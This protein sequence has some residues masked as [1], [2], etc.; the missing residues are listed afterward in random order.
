MD[1]LK[2]TEK[3]PTEA[4]CYAK[5]ERVRWGNRPVCPKCGCTRITKRTARKNYYHCNACNRDFTA[6]YGT[7]F[8]GSKMP[9]RKWFLLI[10][11][12]LNSKKGV[13]AMNLSR[14]VGVTYKTA[15]YSAM[16]VRCA[17]LDWGEE[18]EGI[19]E[20]DETY[21]GGKPRKR[22]RPL[23]SSDNTAD[24]SKIY[25]R[26]DVSV[27]RGRGTKKVPVAGIV[28]R[29]GR[30]VAKVMSGLTSKELLAML[31]RSVKMKDTTLMTDDFRSYNA[32]DAEIER[33]V[34]KHSA[35]E[36]ARGAVHTNTIEGFWSIIKNGIKGSYTKISRAY[37]PF[38]LAEYTYR[39]NRRQLSPSEAF[40]ETV[41]NAVESEKPFTGYKPVR[42]ARKI[43]YPPKKR[44]GRKKPV[45]KN[46]GKRGNKKAVR[47]RKK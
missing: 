34:V 28:E 22:N 19:V 12:M 33:F 2:L 27:K 21:V 4:A 38:Y 32:M 23:P 37:L 39:Y 47:S 16:R 25:D 35:K 45:C 18:L 20:M 15:W 40:E 26:T 9:L 3:Y 31:K 8:E 7:I 36:Y 24:L 43:A 44:A 30:V 46:T 6:L 14:T 29:K 5:I 41:G 17:M 13:S 10:A 42:D 11:V 1:L